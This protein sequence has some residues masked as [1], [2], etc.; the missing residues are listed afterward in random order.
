M[1]R[2]EG[3]ALKLLVVVGF[4]LRIATAGF[5]RPNSVCRYYGIADNQIH[6]LVGCGGTHLIGFG[7]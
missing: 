1:V 6:A 2:P 4:I 3:Y 5:A 7:S